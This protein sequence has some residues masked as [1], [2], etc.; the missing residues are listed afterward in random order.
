[1]IVDG[2]GRVICG[3]QGNGDLVANMLQM[4]NK[5]PFFST[6]KSKN[7]TVGFSISIC[8]TPNQNHL[9]PLRTDMFQV[10]GNMLVAVVT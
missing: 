4:R 10:M 6:K 9:T 3:L 1:M 7:R 5:S 8:Y 2:V